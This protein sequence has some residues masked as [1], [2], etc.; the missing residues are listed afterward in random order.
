MFGKSTPLNRT[1]I[2]LNVNPYANQP[3]MNDFIKGQFEAE[4]MENIHKIILE[5]EGTD[6]LFISDEE[7]ET[8]TIKLQELFAFADVEQTGLFLTLT[9]EK[10][11]KTITLNGFDLEEKLYNFLNKARNFDAMLYQG[12]GEVDDVPVVSNVY[13]LSD[14]HYEADFKNTDYPGREKEMVKS[15]IV[16]PT[17]ITTSTVNE[18]ICGDCN[19]V[20]ASTVTVNENYYND[21]NDVIDGAAYPLDDEQDVKAKVEINDE[22]TLDRVEVYDPQDLEFPSII[23][24]YAEEGLIIRMGQLVH[25]VKTAN[26]PLQYPFLNEDALN[27][28]VAYL[29]TLNEVDDADILNFIKFGYDEM[30]NL[31]STIKDWSKDRR[32]QKKEKKREAQYDEDRQAE[33]NDKAKREQQEQEAKQ[34]KEDKEARQAEKEAAKEVKQQKKE[35]E[36]RARELEVKQ[37][38]QADKF[39]D[40]ISSTDDLGKLSTIEAN[41][42]TNKTLNDQQKSALAKA[43]QSKKASIKPKK[44]ENKKIKNKNLKISKAA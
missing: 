5:F 44:E 6:K 19:H 21:P 25:K 18:C 7:I 34:N 33:K 20:D 43:V 11:N 35:D 29:T 38:E 10:S 41:I 32:E 40:Q 36:D 22:T 26:K 16:N 37:A 30:K 15:E 14:N 2:V 17:H 24:K 42:N 12:N 31:S 27:E 23:N 28:A 9:H 8:L 39:A 1:R 13:G 3:K 4:D